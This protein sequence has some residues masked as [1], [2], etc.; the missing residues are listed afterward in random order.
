MGNGTG[1]LPGVEDVGDDVIH[2]RAML[3]LG[4]DDRAGTTHGVS[5]AFHYAEIG[6]HGGGQIGLVDDQEVGLSDPGTAFAWDLIAAG[7]I[8]DINGVIGQL[9][10]E[11]RG[12]VIAAGLDQQDL[13]RESVMKILEG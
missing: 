3:D 5:V 10:A 2:A 9:A 4:E 12:E 8:D 6:A 13:G 7:D 11:V 1:V